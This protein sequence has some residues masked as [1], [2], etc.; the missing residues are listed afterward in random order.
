MAVKIDEAGLVRL[1]PEIEQVQ[2]PKLRKG[3]VDIWLEIAD[4]CAWDRFEDVPKNLDYEKGRRLVD[5]IR[6]VTQMALELA[7]IGKRLHG[8]DYNREYLLVSCLLHDVSKVVETEPDPSGK[9]TGGP[10]LPG[11]KSELGAKIQHAG[12]ATHKV[13]AHGLPLE[14]AHLVLTH[15]HASGLRSNTL[16]ASYLFYADFADSDI[17]VIQGKGKTFAS[18]IEFV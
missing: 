8:Q 11:K 14:V 15:T 6:G 13:F 2:D 12:Y 9:P 10:A 17:G 7:E 18:R 4:E 3:V 16:E 1:F 5:H